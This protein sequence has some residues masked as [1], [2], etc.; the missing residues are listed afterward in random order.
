[1]FKKILAL[2]FGIAFLVFIVVQYNDPDPALWMVIY[3]L[4]A[5][6][7]FAAAFDKVNHALLWIAAALYVA[8]GINMW[9]AEYE[10]I[11]IGGGDIKNIEEARE[12]LGLFLCS[13]AFFSFILLDK[14]QMNSKKQVSH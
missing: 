11:S 14:L 6:F 1:M 5:V 8:G 4:A 2:L 9:P 10:G 12:S 3:G 7:S 13:I